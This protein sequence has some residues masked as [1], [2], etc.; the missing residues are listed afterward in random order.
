MNSIAHELSTRNDK[1]AG[2]QDNAFC[3]DLNAHETK[4]SYDAD[5][6]P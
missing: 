4:D 5:Y 3:F 6:H 2:N 1:K